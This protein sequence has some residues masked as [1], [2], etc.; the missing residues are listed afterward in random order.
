MVRLVGAETGPPRLGTSGRQVA[1]CRRPL[2]CAAC[3]LHAPRPLAH[4]AFSLSD[5]WA[6]AA[7][8]TSRS[9]PRIASGTFTCRSLDPTNTPGRADDELSH[10]RARRPSKPGPCLIGQ[11]GRRR[12]VT[13]SY[14]HPTSH[15]P[16]HT[17]HI[18][19]RTLLYTR[20]HRWPVGRMMLPGNF[21]RPT[22][23][24]TG[25]RAVPT[26]PRL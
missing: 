1:S 23:G 16:H 9:V 6:A 11:S 4:V 19:H 10:A 21:R 12:A 7:A 17:S 15:I 18:T 13:P 3:G 2:R 14:A 5:S 26:P 24:G 25:W 22:D 8:T 20:R